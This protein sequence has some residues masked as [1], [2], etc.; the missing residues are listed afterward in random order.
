MAT[1]SRIADLSSPEVI[2]HFQQAFPYGQLDGTAVK[3]TADGRSARGTMEMDCHFLSTGPDN[4]A[5]LTSGHWSLTALNTIDFWMKGDGNH[6][7]VYLAL[8]DKAGHSAMIGPM[9]G[10]PD[11]TSDSKE[12]R[13]FSIDLEHDAATA[14]PDMDWSKITKIG[15]MVTDGGSNTPYEVKIVFDDLKIV[16]RPALL[17][18][19]PS[20]FSPNGDGVSDAVHI[21]ML[22][23]KAKNATA[24][25]IDS[26]GK[27][28]RELKLSRTGTMDWNADW[29]GADASGNRLPEG[30]YSCSVTL[31]KA[32]G[33]FPGTAS[34]KLIDAPKL[35][36]SKP[37]EGFFPIG[38]WFE[39]Y[40]AGNGAPRDLEGA[41]KYYEA[42]FA[43]LAAH[44]IDTVAIANGVQPELWGMM[45]NEAQKYNIKVILEVSPLADM[46]ASPKDLDERDVYKAAKEITDKL[47]GYPA[48]LRYQIRDEPQ[49]WQIPNWLI[50]KRVLEDLDPSHPAFSCFNDVSVMDKMYAQTTINDI[51]RDYYPLCF[52]QPDSKTLREYAAA[53]D[54]SVNHSKG[55]PFWMVLQTF[56]SDDKVKYPLRYP[57]GE[58]VRL[59]TYL[60]LTRGA[61]GIF[62]FIYQSEQG[63]KGLSDMQ[64]RPT[65][66]FAEVQKLSAELK[67]LSPTMLS[68]S[69]TKS[70]AKGDD[71]TE[72]RTFKDNSGSRYV[73]LANYDTK[74]ARTVALTIDRSTPVS[75]LTNV[76]TGE[77]ISVFNGSASVELKPGDGVVFKA[78]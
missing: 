28:V 36:T 60:A 54:N 73:I 51:T 63:W 71:E 58:E 27:T 32:G 16:E 44:G 61:K 4:V 67:K 22:A 77:R 12:W 10:H 49:T 34:V 48:L 1:E 65:P 13:H 74:S 40:S 17:Q 69:P 64:H 26:T 59:M 33:S 75:S 20:I 14:G 50:V 6:S 62:F 41:T 56:G 11:M 19:R 57:T 24:K 38:A 35:K 72:V 29:D 9:F 76:L 25:V 18:V 21:S 2:G 45:L 78:E 7:E 3:W 52:D 68:L 39:G 31:N 53:M 30:E 42:S 66:I 70:F 15:F 47:R 43:D 23:S 37:V 46:V 55:R 5:Y 8:G